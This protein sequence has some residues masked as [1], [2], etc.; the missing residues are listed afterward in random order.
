MPNLQRRRF[1]I[2][3]GDDFG[4]SA[5][6]NQAIIT[7]HEQGVLT[8]TSLM[9][10]GD[11][12]QEAIAWARSH[13]NL[14]VGLH[15]V[16]VCGRSV[17]PPSQIPHLVDTSGNFADSPLVAGLR[18]QFQPAAR[19]ELRQEIR[20]QLQKF[21]DSG[22]TLSHVDGHL[23]LH[24]HPV[25][26]RILVE[27]APEFD[28]RVIRLPSEELGMTLKLDRRDLLT[29][30]VWSAV[31]GGLRR[32]GEGLLKSH[33]I[34]FADRVYGLLQTSNISEEYLLGLIPQ[35]Q[36]D[37]VEIYAHPAVIN[38]GE[39]LNGPPASGEM[40]LGALLSGRVR[41]VLN[42]HGFELTNYQKCR[43]NGKK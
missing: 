11:A 35:I 22:L 31:F 23:H 20:A 26:L 41:Q 14:A 12:A 32:Y 33:D 34:R 25:I 1:A 5:G 9:V 37:L 27:L 18:Y 43:F 28:I 39:P 24:A 15:L 8:S 13:P 7:A 10:T 40:E 21:R 6:V 38:P 36:A 3:N 42:V 16:L 29:K 19:E 17:L 2:I 4:F 30:L